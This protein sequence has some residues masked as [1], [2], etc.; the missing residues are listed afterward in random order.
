MSRTEVRKCKRS[1]ENRCKK[2]KENNKKGRISCLFC[3]KKMGGRQL[4]AAKSVT[5]SAAAQNE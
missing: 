4:E 2:E 5:V 1:V 3:L